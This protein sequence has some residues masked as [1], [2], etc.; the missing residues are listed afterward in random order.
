MG[1]SEEVKHQF[2]LKKL[3]YD[4]NCSYIQWEVKPKIMMKAEHLE[5]IF[6]RKIN[7]KHRK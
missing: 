6:M 3:A 1:Y 5:E 4:Q 7:K 2:E